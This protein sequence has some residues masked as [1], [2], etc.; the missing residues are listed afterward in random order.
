MIELSTIENITSY[1]GR[2]DDGELATAATRHGVDL[3]ALRK[4]VNAEFKAKAP[5]K[6]K[7]PKAK[8]APKAAAT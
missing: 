6:A 5:T 1:A 8:R 4:E 3:P 2:F 7:K